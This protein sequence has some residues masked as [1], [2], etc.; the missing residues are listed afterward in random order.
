MMT[1]AGD[2]LG[3][4]LNGLPKMVLNNLVSRPPFARVSQHALI[5]LWQ[6]MPSHCLCSQIW[7][8]FVAW[9]IFKIIFFHKSKRHCCPL[10]KSNK[11]SSYILFFT[12]FPIANY[13]WEKLTFGEHFEVNL[14]HL[15]LTVNHLG[16]ENVEQAPK[17]VTFY[18]VNNFLATWKLLQILHENLCVILVIAVGL[19]LPIF[20][21]SQ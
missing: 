8:N 9:A 1:L 16:R 10:F 4:F 5:R 7:L 15:F 19:K 21:S 6:K 13:F 3:Y 17:K 11:I 14:M 12:V 20:S 18:C 2:H